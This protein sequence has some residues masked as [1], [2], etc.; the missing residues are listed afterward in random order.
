MGSES[1]YTKINFSLYFDFVFQV[2]FQYLPQMAL[3]K[4]KMF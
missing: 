4:I 3:R 1:S 2:S